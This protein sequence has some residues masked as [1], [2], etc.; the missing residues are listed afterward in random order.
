[1]AEMHTQIASEITISVNDVI[2]IDD[3]DVGDAVIDSVRDAVID[4]FMTCII[5]IKI[6]QLLH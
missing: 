2:I 4:L 5:R 1:M 6:L 3:Y